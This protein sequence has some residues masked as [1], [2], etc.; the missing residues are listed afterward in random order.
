VLGAF[1]LCLKRGPKQTAILPVFC[2]GSKR[3]TEKWLVLEYNALIR[4]VGGMTAW[5]LQN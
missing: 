1:I 5:V 2:L 3:P 4:G